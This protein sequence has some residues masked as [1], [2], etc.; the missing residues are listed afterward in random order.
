MWRGWGETT[1]QAWWGQRRNVQEFQNSNEV[2]LYQE[3]LE[4]TTGKQGKEEVKP[5][6]ETAV[7]LCLVS[8]TQPGEN[9]TA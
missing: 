3:D 9:G 5:S 6:K 4:G 2:G 8:P 7:A 1:P